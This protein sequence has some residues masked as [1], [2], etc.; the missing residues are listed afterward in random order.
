MKHAAPP[1]GRYG[2]VADDYGRRES[3]ERLGFFALGER[4]RHSV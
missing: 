1:G 3:A 4:Q 2:Q